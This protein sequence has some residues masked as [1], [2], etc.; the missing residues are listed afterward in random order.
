MNYKL[1]KPCENCPFVAGKH[2]DGW[3]GYKRALEISESNTEFVCHK[4]KDSDNPQH[5]AGKLIM[6]E[7]QKAP[8]QM[9]RIAERLGIYNK[10][11]LIMDS[12]V[13]DDPYEMAQAHEITK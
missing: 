6:S 3:L 10:Q 12:N 4:T 2:S 5:C 13:F 1:T 9:M 8:H 11:E 7:N